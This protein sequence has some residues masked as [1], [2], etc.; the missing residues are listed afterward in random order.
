MSI[1][2]ST[3]RARGEAMDGAWMARAVML[4]HRG[5]A[6]AHPNPMVGAVV[7]RNDRIV[8]EGFHTYEGRKHAEVIALEQTRGEARGATLYVNLEPCCH[9][10]R[11]GPCTNAIIAA[12][13]KRVVVAMKDP[14]PKVAGRGI[15][16]LRR[17][18]L[19]VTIGVRQAEARRLN[20]AFARWIGSGLPFVTLKSALTLD[21]QI[22]ALGGTVTWIT[23]PASREE[24]QRLR[25]SSDGL[26][27]GIGTVLA[28]NPRM[29]DRTG[30]P[31]RKRLLRVIIDSKLRLPLK[32]RIVRSVRKKD[33]LAFTAESA[34]TAKARALVKAGVEVVQTSSH[35]GHVDLKAILLEL[36]RREVLSVILEAGGGLNGAMLEAGLVD[37]AI[38]FYAPKIL[39]T[40]TVPVAQYRPGNIGKN[41]TLQNLA[42]RR[43]GPDFA[44]EGYLRD[45]YRNH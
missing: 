43:F 29:S 4:A 11:T 1:P 13:L 15:A 2:S 20:E 9:S 40:V 38:L 23:S 18:G 32:S 37:K 12:G 8:G 27:T 16:E 39:G 7:V 34:K 5:V 35:A 45:V 36:G 42:L 10:G 44:V 17:A 30:L 3:E 41:S 26:L 24:V 22:T 25:H 31:R 19:D 33:V 28:D 6:L 14:N 21:G